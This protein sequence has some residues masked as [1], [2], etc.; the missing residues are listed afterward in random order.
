MRPVQAAARALSARQL[1]AR[2]RRLGVG[3]GRWAIAL[4]GGPDSLALAVLLADIAPVRAF[5][6]DHGLREESAREARLVQRHARE[7][8]ITAHILRWQG[9]KPASGIMAAAREARYRLLIEAAHKHKCSHLFLAHHL[10]DQLETVAMRHEE[11]SGWLGL[12]GM[13]ALSRLGNVTLVRPTLDV[14]KAVLEA[15][16][17]VRGLQAVQDPS[18]RNPRYARARLRLSGRDLTVMQERQREAALRRNALLRSLHAEEGKSYRLQNGWAELTLDRSNLGNEEK[19]ELLRALLQSVGQDNQPIRLEALKRALARLKAGQGATLAG[20]ILTSGLIVREPAAIPGL[21]LGAGRHH[22][23]WDR[24][25]RL[26]FSVQE[27]SLLAP[28][29]R[30]ANWRSLKGAGWVEAMPGAARASLPALWQQ[31]RLVAVL[32]GVWQPYYHPLSAVFV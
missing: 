3:Q 7:R 31:G 11:G 9:E 2:L 30:N 19:A 23:W 4:S 26:G 6:V 10:D 27:Q 8:G 13:P 15:T 20:C 32:K 22:I 12:A 18:N 5:I 25:W 1:Q 29:G 17:R 14:P 16:C 21:A 24:R 28:L